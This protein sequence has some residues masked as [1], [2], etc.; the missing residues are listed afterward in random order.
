MKGP[1]PSDLRRGKGEAS[2]GA[3]RKLSYGSGRGKTNK[4]SGT[5]TRAEEKSQQAEERPA[6][7][8]RPKGVELGWVPGARP[9]SQSPRN[10]ARSLRGRA[11]QVCG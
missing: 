9:S 4:H 6:A 11:Q 8:E 7:R 1:K 5:H 3:K 2:A 10:L